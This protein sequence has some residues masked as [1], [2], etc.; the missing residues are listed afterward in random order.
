MSY[1]RFVFFNVFGGIGWVASMVLLGYFLPSWIDPPFKWLLGQQFEVRNH[2]E[3]V[4]IVVVLLSVSPGF[5][6]WVRAKA[7]SRTVTPERMPV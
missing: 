5:F 4:I 6:A 1:P 3:K 2:I 7:K